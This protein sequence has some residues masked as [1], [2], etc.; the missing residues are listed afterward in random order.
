MGK[1]RSGNRKAIRDNLI[2]LVQ[3]GEVTPADA[4]SQA[5]QLGLDPLASEPDPIDY[6]PMREPFWTL[7][8]A[9]AWIAYRTQE[10]VRNWWDEYRR[11]CWDWH[12]RE[13]RVGPDGPIHQGHFLEQRI[14]ATLVLLKMAGMWPGQ[15]GLMSVAEAIDT[16]WLVLRSGGLEA[17]GIDEDT[18]RRVPIPAE[19][20]MI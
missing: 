18:G 11:E 20:G 1:E 5:K 14:K 12:F 8:M 10:A 19:Q 16:L 15:G 6:D 9:V 13:W 17:T 3:R 7:P 4:E 2:T